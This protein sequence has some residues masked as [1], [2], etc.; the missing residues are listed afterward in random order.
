MNWGSTPR[1]SAKGRARARCPICGRT[2]YMA[3]A[4]WIVTHYDGMRRCVGSGFPA[5]PS[6]TPS[7]TEEGG[8]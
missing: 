8:T 1:R 3:K 2:Y 7:Q 4:G 5:D 6:L